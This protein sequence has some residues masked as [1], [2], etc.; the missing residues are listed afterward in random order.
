MQ[1]GYAG[2]SVGEVAAAAGVTKPTLYYHFGDKEGL[3][4]AVIRALLE[5]VGGYISEIAHRTEPASARL[6]Q[7]ARGYFLHADYTMEPMLRDVAQLVSPER[8]AD[9]RAVY[10]RECFAPIEY[11]MADGIARHEL[12]SSLDSHLL[13]RAFLALLEAFTA[14]GGHTTRTPAEHAAV[15]R[16]V[17]ALFWGGAC[18][19]GRASEVLSS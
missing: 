2:V 16:S 17:V 8:A 14:S 11:L 18:G 15:A 6:V 1:R 4:A 7:I 13:A 12:R 3:Y 9:L 5:E 19:E 10:E